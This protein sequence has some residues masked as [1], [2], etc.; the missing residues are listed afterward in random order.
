MFVTGTVTEQAISVTD[1]PFLRHLGQL[2]P[3]RSFSEHDE[4]VFETLNIAIALDLVLE[5]GDH[6][7]EL[8]QD[9]VQATLRI[10]AQL[11]TLT[12]QIR[13]DVRAFHAADVYKT[14]TGVSA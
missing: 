1:R 7:S 4:T 12:K 5:A 11:V 3:P 13:A 8:D 6:A 14:G 9:E 2:T 10:S